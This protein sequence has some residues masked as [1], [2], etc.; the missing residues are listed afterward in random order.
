[1]T[2]TNEATGTVDANSSTAL[3]VNTGGSTITNNGT[4]EA[5]GDTLQVDQAVSGTGSATIGAGG[6]IDFLGAFSQNVTYAG[7]TGELDL[8]HTLTTDAQHYAG[9][10]AGIATG[11]S[12][13]IMVLEDMNFVSGHTT[14]SYNT[15]SHVLTVT[16]GTVTAQ[17]NVLGS[18]MANSFV[19]VNDGGHV[20]V[21]D[22]VSGSASPL[23]PSHT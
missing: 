15:M 5:I 18:F 8:A 3:T 20:E 1:L 11:D 10:V 6:R 7:T 14:A 23:V 16:N 21:H 9:T 22:P 12:G 2:F 17:L 4:L 19:A 13:D